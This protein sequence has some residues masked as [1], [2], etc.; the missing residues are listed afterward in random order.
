MKKQ[1]TSP[2][3]SLTKTTV[4]RYTKSHRLAGAQPTSTVISSS[5][6]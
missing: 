6:M 3:F 2:M 4:T 1:T 5:F